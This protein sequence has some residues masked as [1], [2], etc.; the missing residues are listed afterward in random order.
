M[1]TS[2]LVRNIMRLCFLM[3]RRYAPCS[4]MLETAF[5]RLSCAGAL[6]PALTAALRSGNW[7]EREASPTTIYEYLARYHHSL[8]I[9]PPLSPEVSPFYKR[10]FVVI[11]ADRFAEAIQ[12][13]IEDPAVLA[14]P[15]HRGGVD[16]YTDSTPLLSDSNLRRLNLT[17][18]D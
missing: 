16:Q 12:A 7:R 14:L 17:R 3:E 6:T 10:P 15:P 1:V 11:H 18:I 8:A 13:Q 9:T 2:R 5:G 4:K